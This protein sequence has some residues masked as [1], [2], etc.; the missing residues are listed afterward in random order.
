MIDSA[1]SFR[2]SQIKIFIT[3]AFFLQGAT[4][5]SH[6][7]ELGALPV[8]GFPADLRQS[9]IPIA[10]FE[11][12]PGER[13][14][15]P[16]NGEKVNR[17]A[18]HQKLAD[19]YTGQKYAQLGTLGL[20]GLANQKYDEQLMLYIANSL[21]WTNRTKEAAQ[22]YRVLV[23][24]KYK[25]DATLGL[26]NIHRWSGRDH[27]AIP[28]YKELLAA[29][30]QNKD[31]VEGMRLAQR[32]VVPRSTVV[33]GTSTDSSMIDMQ[34]LRVAHR[35]RDASMSHQ[36]EIE[37]TRV[38]L[39][40]PSLDLTRQSIGL[41]YKGLEL[42]FRPTAELSLDS[43][44]IYGTAT[45]EL[46]LPIRLDIGKVNWGLISTNPLALSRDLTALRLG[47]QG[48]SSHSLGQLQGRVEYNKV[49]DGNIVISANGRFVPSW[50]P[51]GASIKPMLGIETRDA[52]FNTLSYWSP[53]DGYGSIFAGVMGEW[54]GPA[55]NLNAS[56]QGGTRI[57]GEAGTS[58]SYSSSGKWWVHRDW[59]LGMNLWSMGSQRNNIPYRA[60]SLFF[61]VEKLWQ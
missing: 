18:E 56:V 50:R 61:T 4:V 45:A 10:P 13:W 44:G 32:E 43:K 48:S 38:N 36:W 15:D 1:N 40:N 47:I 25:A 29:N 35:W 8:S 12:V 42:P 17:S 11:Y 26:A 55:W 14:K 52:K 46:N 21:A 57:F 59:A 51:L 22:L 27:L 37:T 58:W 9:I 19:L 24:G 3:L 6:A 2:A 41:R 39:K 20:E 16:E 60:R 54:S 5:A 7:N 34:L 31:A 28:L 23:Q 49:S 30:P 53:S 33:L